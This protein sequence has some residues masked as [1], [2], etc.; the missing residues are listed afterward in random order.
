MLRNVLAE[1]TVNADL[2]A[3]VPHVVLRVVT[4]VGTVRTASARVVTSAA[5][6]PTASATPATP[7]RC[8]KPNVREAAVCLY[9]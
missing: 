6:V 5:V 1:P 3:A 4:A 8:R 9:H 2:T 7:S